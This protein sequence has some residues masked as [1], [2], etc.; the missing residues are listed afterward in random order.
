MK[1]PSRRPPSA[2]EVKTARKKAGLTIAR[3]AALVGVSYSAWQAWEDGRNPMHVCYF[4][5]FE[6]LTQEK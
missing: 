6:R 2:E 4:L 3:A 1:V 5:E